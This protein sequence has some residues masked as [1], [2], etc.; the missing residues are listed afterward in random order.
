VLASK[1]TRECSSYHGAG[2]DSLPTSNG[3][4]SPIV[5]ESGSYKIQSG[6]AGNDKPSLVFPNNIQNE[7]MYNLKTTEAWYK[8]NNLYIQKY[9]TKR[10]KPENRDKD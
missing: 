10:A 1:V 2:P 4:L 5:L 3:S 7:V 9:Y 6:F 8:F